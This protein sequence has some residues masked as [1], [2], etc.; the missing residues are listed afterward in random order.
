MGNIFEWAKSKGYLLDTDDTQYYTNPAASGASAADYRNFIMVMNERITDPAD[1]LLF[2][3][4]LVDMG[5][6]PAGTNAAY[7]ANN[8]WVGTADTIENL[9]DVVSQAFGSLSTDPGGLS[10]QFPPINESQAAAGTTTTSSS[11]PPIF[12]PPGAPPGSDMT[13]YSGATHYIVDVDGVNEHYLVYDIGT[14]ESPFLVAYSVGTDA[15]FSAAFPQGLPGLNVVNNSWAQWNSSGLF[16]NVVGDI[17]EMQLPDN[18]NM[19]L[20]QQIRED[21]ALLGL[22]GLPTWMLND[23]TAMLGAV[24]AANE[25]WSPD[26]LAQ[27]MHDNSQGFKNRFPGFDAYMALHGDSTVLGNLSA[28]LDEEEAL[29]AIIHHFRGTT[30][31]E[32]SAAYLGQLIGQGWTATEAGNVLS[33]ELQFNDNPEALDDLNAILVGRGLAP[34]RAE[35]FLNLLVGNVD[36]LPGEVFDAINDALFL[37]AL[38]QQGLEVDELLGETFG[39]TVAEAVAGPGSFDELARDIAVAINDARIDLAVGKFNLTAKDLIVG[40]AEGQG[41]ILGRLAQLS[42]ERKVAGEGLGGPQSGID[43]RG[44]LRIAGLQNI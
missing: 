32:L 31:P 1:R 23:P 42:R 37:D 8:E 13:I 11:L 34:V 35:D 36:A 21:L 22:E 16:G 4:G 38:T 28:Y 29:R 5:A 41:E 14:P 3:Q 12:Q 19:S 2:F 25:E 43:E 9:A 6:L 10:G 7:W 26:R 39:T 40:L 18:I 44:R 24:Q 33:A 27:W 15:E 17:D 20:G 30:G